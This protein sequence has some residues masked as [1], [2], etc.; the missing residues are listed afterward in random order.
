MSGPREVPAATVANLCR[1]WE[2]ILEARYPGTRWHVH[3]RDT[4]GTDRAPEVAAG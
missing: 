3:T 1:T 2:S 4:S